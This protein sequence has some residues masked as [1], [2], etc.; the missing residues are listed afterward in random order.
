MNNKKSQTF[1]GNF[2]C[3]QKKNDYTTDLLHNAHIGFL[4]PLWSVDVWAGRTHIQCLWA[5]WAVLHVPMSLL[6]CTDIQCSLHNMLLQTQA[7]LLAT[8]QVEY[9]LASSCTC[10]QRLVDYY[11]AKAA[12]ERSLSCRSYN[13]CV[14][15]CHSWFHQSKLHE[16]KH[17]MLR[18]LIYWCSDLAPPPSTP[19]LVLKVL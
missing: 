13:S 15:L 7:W 18:Y 17:G 6:Q 16:K 2:W 11:N 12:T 4:S 3:S 19:K 8:W 9:I 14:I 1:Q 5:A 10:Q